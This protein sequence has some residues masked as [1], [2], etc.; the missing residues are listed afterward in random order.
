MHTPAPALRHLGVRRPLGVALEEFLQP[1]SASLGHYTRVQ[2]PAWGAGRGLDEG[3]S[4]RGLGEGLGARLDFSAA[5]TAW[6]LARHGLALP[7]LRALVDVMVYEY[8]GKSAELL[9]P[10]IQVPCAPARTPCGCTR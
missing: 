4:L 5:V 7:S 3:D 2:P 1:L 6:F 9:E 10:A 8:S